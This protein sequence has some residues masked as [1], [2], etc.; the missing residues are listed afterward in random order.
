MHSDHE[1]GAMN[2]RIFHAGLS[3]EAVS[4][5]LLCCGL[6]DEGKT[7]SVKNLLSIWNSTHESLIMSLEALEEKNIIQKMLT[8]GKGNTIYEL[9]DVH[10][11]I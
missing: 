6:A 4:A 8:D 7:I 1:P 11:W 2:Q 9:M 3:T 10:A 5:Y